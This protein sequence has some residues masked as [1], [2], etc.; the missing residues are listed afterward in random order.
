MSNGFPR[1]CVEETSFQ[2]SD[3]DWEHRERLLEDF[4]RLMIRIRNEGQA[5]SKSSTLEYAEVRRDIQLVNLL[6]GPEA[7]LIDRDLRRLLTVTLDR[8]N[9]W[10]EHFQAQGAVCTVSGNAHRS[11]SLE[12]VAHEVSQRRGVCCLCIDREGQYSG[13]H[14]V[15]SGDLTATISFVTDPTTLLEFYRS[16]IEIENLAESA[17]IAHA[18]LAFPDLYFIPG[19]EQQFRRFDHGY[20]EL[21]EDITRHLSALNDHFREVFQRN[22]FQEDPVCREF[23]AR[24]AVSMST[25]SPNTRRNRTAMAQRNVLVNNEQLSCVWHTK[26]RP[27]I[28]R[29]HFHPGNE[30]VA[31]GRIVIAIFVNHLMT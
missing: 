1:F 30:N 19:I 7:H 23:T 2:F 11:E 13:L 17:Y 10:D 28:D 16:I 9:C 5:I 31:G 20:H 6:Y 27:T 3:L 18:R 26:L 22:R 21:R 15:N 29:I 14:A 8:C 25:E 4:S 12:Y 24:F